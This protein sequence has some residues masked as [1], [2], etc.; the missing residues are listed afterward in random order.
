MFERLTPPANQSLF[1]SNDEAVVLGASAIEP[2]HLL[3]AILAEP[4]PVITHLFSTSNV[5]ARTLR[6]RIH[7]RTGL[8][9]S[10]FDKSVTL[11]FSHNTIRVLEYTAQEADRLLHHQIGQEHMLLGLLSVE[12][13]VASDVLREHGLSLTAMREALVMHV[14]AT[15]PP[16]PEIAG[17]LAGMLPGHAPRVDRR[18]PAYVMT[19][20]DGPSPGRR[21]ATDDV[22]SGGLTTGRVG[23]ATRADRP[24][25]G[26]MHS[27]GPISMSATTLPQLAV[28]LEEFLDAPV[29]VDHS[30]QNGMFAIELQGQYDTPEALIAAVRAQLG[31]ALTRNAT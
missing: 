21:S 29:V 25:D 4:D 20:L 26:R 22:G 24:P 27:I 6:E 11:P 17:I 3:L 18:G 15:S 19:A 7:A 13:G 16:P 23:F 8:P 28:V 31:L 30:A 12:T 10:P 5:T 9:A 2:E 14:S 1:G